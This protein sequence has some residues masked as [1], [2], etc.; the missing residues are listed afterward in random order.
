MNAV[1][2]V[3]PGLLLPPAFRAHPPHRCPPPTAGGA[4]QW[5]SCCSP[6][7]SHLPVTEPRCPC[8]RAAPDGIM[9]CMPSAWRHTQQEEGLAGEG[10]HGTC[11]SLG[12]GTGLQL[13]W[14]WSHPPKGNSHF[15]SHDMVWLTLLCCSVDTSEFPVPV[16]ES[17]L[18]GI[19]RNGLERC[20]NPAT[21]PEF[22][23]V[24]DSAFGTVRVNHQAFSAFTARDGDFQRFPALLCPTL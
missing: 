19:L 16:P 11:L 2:A 7:V 23:A 8:A 9:A 24:L 21:F 5:K 4:V 20:L 13:L 10:R 15:Y 3:V 6:C 14:T 22:L 18:F 12:A 17:A 1:W